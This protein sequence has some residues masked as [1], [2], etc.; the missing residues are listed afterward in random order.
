MLQK[1]KIDVST[2]FLQLKGYTP[3]TDINIYARNKTVHRYELT[4]VADID[5]HIYIIESFSSFFQNNA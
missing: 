2:A 5:I 1:R 4:K 3:R